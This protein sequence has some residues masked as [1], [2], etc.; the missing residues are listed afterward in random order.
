MHYTE[1]TDF[2]GMDYTVSNIPKGEYD[3]CTFTGCNFSA[4][5]LSSVVFTDCEFTDCNFSNAKVR[6][7]GFKEVFFKDC[8]MTGLNFSVADPFLI[9]MHFTDCQLNL[10]SFYQLKLKKACFTNCNL[11]EADLTETDFTEASFTNCDFKHAIFENTILEKADLR[12][13]VNYSIDPQQNRIKKAKFSLPAV[14]GL[15]DRFNIVI[16]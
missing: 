16:E 8:K 11:Q 12:S 10:T 3:N 14:T 7:T 2:K 6:G 13:A 1:G 9:A 4:C 15:L 5:D